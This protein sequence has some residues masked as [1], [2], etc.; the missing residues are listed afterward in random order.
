M[1]N[2]APSPPHDAA[3]ALSRSLF[4]FALCAWLPMCLA[5]VALALA[6][7]PTQSAFAQLQR[8]VLLGFGAFTL[9]AL[10]LLVW[11]YRLEH[12]PSA[13][14]ANALIRFWGSPWLAFGWLLALL[15]LNILAGALL[16]QVAPAITDPARL[17]LFCW[18]LVCAGLV[19]TIHWRGLS[20]ALVRRRNQLAL[21]FVALAAIAL[22]AL[23]TLLTSR[24]V[25]AYGW[26]DQLRGRLDYRPLRFIDDGSAT[27]PSASAFWMEQSQTRVRWLPYSYWA[28]AP[29]AGHFINVAEDGLRRT[30]SERDIS[31]PTVYF[32]GGSTAWGEGARDAYTIPSQVA[33]LLGERDHAVNIVNYAQTGYV[34]GQDLILFQRQLALGNL[35]DLAVFY[36]GFNDVYSAFTGGQAGLPMQEIQRAAD[37]EA[38]RLLRQNQPVLRSLAVNEADLNW[39]LAASGESS[40]R[41][42]LDNW[43]ANRRLIRAAASEFGVDVLFIWQP[44]FFAK[45]SLSSF[46][47]QFAA[48]IERSLPGFMRL[49]AEV[50]Q[51]LRQAPASESSGD[52]LIISDLFADQEDE[53][54]IDE[55]HINEVGNQAVAEAIVPEIAARLRSSQP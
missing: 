39:T 14:I 1:S 6:P 43:N 11:L 54:F 50:D 21:A 34:S 19:M 29:F 47:A 12:R 16:P 27:A 33:R 51:L 48:E 32:F 46:E 23:L 35:P 41:A 18:S 26:H 38:G 8:L 45:R 3:G 5:F 31:Q 53:I 49:Y 4:G 15:E 37:A 13:R 52:L 55:A 17:L 2:R 25:A 28:V 30:V 40:P 24:L 44:A 10:L 36:Q 22:F 7:S 20:V 9:L 42:I